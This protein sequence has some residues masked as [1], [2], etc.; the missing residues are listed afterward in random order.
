LAETD[1]FVD[2][3]MQL[4]ELADNS[5]LALKKLSMLSGNQNVLPYLLDATKKI[6]ESG[7]YIFM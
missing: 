4:Y 2:F 1:E 3:V 7:K 6:L 5:L